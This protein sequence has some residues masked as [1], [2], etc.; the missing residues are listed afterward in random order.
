MT[1]S[2]RRLDI[3]LSTPPELPEAGIQAALAVLRGGRLF[4]YGEDTGEERHAAALEVEFAALLGRRYAVAMNS[5]GA[6]LFAALA[7]LGVAPSEPVL[8]TSFTLAPVPGAIAH[9][10]ARGVAVEVDA[11]LRIDL[12]SLR[13]R[14]QATGAKVLLLSH[15]RGHLPDMD[16]VM[17]TARE[18]GLRVVEDCAHTLGARFRGRPSGSFGDVGCFSTQSFKHVNSGE[19]G[20]LVTDDDDLAARAILLSGSYALWSQHE[21]RPEDDTMRRHEPY[22]PNCSLRMSNLVAALIRPQLPMLPSRAQVWNARY[23]RLA[24]GLAAIP[25]V[26]LP[27]APEGAEG[28]H[29]SIQCFVDD[30]PKRAFPAFLQATA[31]RGV[32]LKWF[33]VEHT[34]GF[35]G[36][37]EHWRYLPPEFSTPRTSELLDKLVDMRIPLTLADGDCDDVVHILGEELAIARS[38]IP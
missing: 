5:C 24:A 21:S 38:Q 18:L 30:L 25:G 36:R 16:A 10:G 33:G 15:M 32:F 26:R 35:T 7:A 14:A 6:T 8:F 20:L 12:E 9:A 29:S 1:R 13:S 27:R 11:D 28:V 17:S 19:G 22:V 37:R 3:T 2:K 4:R 34:V 31:A 23:D